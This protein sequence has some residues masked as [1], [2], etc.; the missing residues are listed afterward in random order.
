MR[1]NPYLRV[2][3]YVWD[4]YEWY[5]QSS[6]WAVQRPGGYN[7]SGWTLCCDTGVRPLS[8]FRRGTQRPSEA[9]HNIALGAPCSPAAM[10]PASCGQTLQVPTGLAGADISFTV[11]ATNNVFWVAMGPAT[12]N[13]DRMDYAQIW[14]YPRPDPDTSP[15]TLPYAVPAAQPLPEFDFRR[16]PWEVPMSEP[17]PEPLPLPLP[18]RVLKPYEEPA[19]QYEAGRAPRLA[20]HQNLKDRTNPPEQSKKRIVFKRGA[21]AR[22]AGGAFG[23]AT[24]G[25]DA[26]NSMWKSIPKEYRTP[27]ATQYQKFKDVWK[28]LDKVQWDDAA[29]DW[30]LSQAQDRALAKFN[31]LGNA[32]FVGRGR[33]AKYW[34]FPTGPAA[35]ARRA[36][37]GGG[38]LRVKQ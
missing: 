5:R 24:E 21:V 32:A 1:L 9:N 2:A 18:A 14:S 22:A 23:A 33:A 16:Y 36:Y 29:V 25:M 19:W 15:L 10:I 28:H 35:G 38:Y 26:V 4:A 13:G 37:G 3:S 7:M 20:P 31:K 30:A 27:R 8:A 12:F 6:D 34:P 11:F 17:I